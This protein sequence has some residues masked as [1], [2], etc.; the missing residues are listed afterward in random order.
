MSGDSPERFH[1]VGPWVALAGFFVAAACSKSEVKATA[2]GAP[3]DPPPSKPSFTVFAVAEMRG[4]IGPCGCTS[5]P[6]GD[7]SRTT[8]LVA[9]ARATGPVLFVD[10]GSLLYSR[11]PIPAQLVTQEDMK[12]DL[13]ADTYKNALK[14]DAL[15]LGPADLPRGLD[16]LR[17]PRLASNVAAIAPEAPKLIALG[18]TKAGVF[19]VI[20]GG[21]VTGVQLGDPIAAAKQ[22]VA[23]LRGQGAQVVIGLVQ[24]A[25]KKDAVKLM[26][27][28]GGID[29][30]VAGL[31]ALAPEPDEVENE[32]Q[33]VGDGW[34]IT[35]AN[36]GQIVARVDVTVRGGGVLVDAVG[37]GAASA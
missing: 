17:L 9:H 10:A 36:R 25:S 12:A 33:R 2:S 21:A 14:V 32:A 34:L 1:R 13:L 18:G 6:L 5:D 29:L 22:V 20:A 27:D 26:R 30:A 35:P 3:A 24:A 19:G 31:G 28:V 8:E 11:S 23:Q 15:G 7:I 37:P 4:Q 16:H